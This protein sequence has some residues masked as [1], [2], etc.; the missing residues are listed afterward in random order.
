[1]NKAK[2]L[3]ASLLVVNVETSK[4]YLLTYSFRCPKFPQNISI[5]SKK[6]NNIKQT[7]KKSLI[8]I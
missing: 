6:Y 1:M 3:S 5:G 7:K 2:K 4:Y 8:F